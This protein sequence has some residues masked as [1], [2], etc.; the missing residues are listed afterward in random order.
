MTV[1][2]GVSMATFGNFSY[3]SSWMFQSNQHGEGKKTEK[4]TN[5]QIN[6]QTTT[7]TTATATTTTTTHTH[8]HTHTHNKNN[9]N[10]NKSNKTTTNKKK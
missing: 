3:V 2:L 4:H 9:N 5:K 8:T 7:T 6:K 10:K 1:R